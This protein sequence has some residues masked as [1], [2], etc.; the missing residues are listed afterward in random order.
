MKIVF[1]HGA[2]HTGELWSDV[3]THFPGAIAPS[4]PGHPDGEAQASVESYAQWLI[5]R[6]LSDAGD[7]RA[8]LVGN[9]MGGAIAMTVALHATERVAALVLIGSGAKLRVHPDIFA[10][11][12]RDFT[13]AARTLAQLQLAPDA[14]EARIARIVAAMERTGPAATIADLRACDAFD[15]RERL[16]DIGAPTLVI[17]G[18]ED[19]MTPPKYAQ[20]LRERIPAATLESLEGAGHVPQLEQPERVARTLAA[21]LGKIGEGAQS[22]R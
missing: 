16:G 14:P 3:Q 20:F 6:H 2:G 11:L 9:S 10:Q 21:F 19:R 1:I 12:E 13:A 18:T 15:L 17:S 5:E 7:G 4:L 22:I 8:V